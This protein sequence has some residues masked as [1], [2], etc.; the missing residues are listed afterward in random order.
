[1]TQEGSRTENG[2]DDVLCTAASTTVL[3]PNPTGELAPEIKAAG[4]GYHRA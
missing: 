2:D 1:M 4:G 3:H